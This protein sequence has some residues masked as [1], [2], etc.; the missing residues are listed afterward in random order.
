MK[1]TLKPLL[2]LPLIASILLTSCKKDE[3]EKMEPMQS[4]TF[5]YAFNT[6]QVGAGTAYDGMHSKDLMASL[7]LEEMSNGKT[8]VTVT[9][10]N[11]QDG[12]N[13]M[14]HSHDA[15][16][17]ATTPNGTPYNEVPNANVLVGVVEGNGGT[18][19]YSQESTM[20]YEQLTTSY[21]A[22]FVV[23]DP[24]QAMSTTDLTTYLVVGTFA[25]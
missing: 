13:Y 18:A 14:V 17:P 25:R 2:I 12:E 11:T 6:G 1:K 9:L 3:E 7:M 8:K 22:F 10:M 5:N 21:E 24:T 19:T 20:S 23:H 4:K 16:D 15:A